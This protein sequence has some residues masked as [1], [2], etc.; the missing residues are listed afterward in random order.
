LASLGLRG[1]G[2]GAFLDA[3]L[4]WSGTDHAGMPPVERL[5]EYEQASRFRLNPRRPLW[6]Q[7]AAFDSRLDE[8]TARHREVAA[9]LDADRAALRSVDRRDAGTLAEWELAGRQG[10]K[11]KPERPVIER[12]I[13]EGE[14]GIEGVRSAMGRRARREGCVR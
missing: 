7:L 13:A 14:R 6:P 1:E 9:A 2:E 8:L 11:P 5:A 10:D 12:R 3:A 4:P